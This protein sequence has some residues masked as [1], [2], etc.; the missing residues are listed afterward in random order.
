MPLKT[1]ARNT[2]S[3]AL[4]LVLTLFSPSLALAQEAAPEDTSGSTSTAAPAEDRGASNTGPTSPT[5]ADAPTYTQNDDGTWSNGTYTWDPNTKQT[6]PNQPQDY[7][8]NPETKMWDTTEYVYHPEQGKYVPNTKSTTANPQAVNAAS[9][10]AADDINTTGPNSTNSVNSDTDNNGMFDLFFNGAISSTIKSNATSGDALVQSNTAAGSALTGDAT[11]IA[12]VLNMLQSSWLGQS[13]D[14]ATFIT[15]IDGNVYGDLTIDPGQLPSGNLSANNGYGGDVDIN[16]SAN[17]AIN[18]DI[19]LVA[20]SGDAT[21][22]SNTRGGDATSGNARAM[23]NIIN[24]INSSIAAGQSFLGM[25]NINGNFDGDILLPPGVLDALIASTGPNSTNNINSNG[26]NNVDINSTANRTIANNVDTDATTGNANVSNNTTAGGANSGQASTGVN[27]LNL[28]G[29]KVTG[30]NGLLV[31]VNVLGKWVGMVVTPNGATIANSGPGSNNS[32]HGTNNNSLSVDAE[33]NSLI[34]NNINASA[35]SGDAN[36]T[37]NTTAGNAT[38]GNAGVTVSL[39]NMI[40]TD[41][42]VE[43]WFGVLF[44][45]VFGEWMG[46]FGADTANGGCSTCAP[47]SPSGGGNG[48]APVQSASTSSGSTGTGQVFGFIAR[49][50][51]GTPSDQQVTQDADNQNTAVFG[52]STTP[53]ESTGTGAGSDISTQSASVNWWI[54]AGIIGMMATITILVRE[55]VLALRE[56]K[57]A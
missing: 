23:A 14:L 24:M 51:T 34:N 52:A 16:V 27:T 28:V 53:G 7:S 13:G 20:Q 26:A 30:K 50:F 15:N 31:F 12:N 8:Y 36:V 56:E 1:T 2:V 46:S 21:V 49:N 32:V 43:D 57:L 37:N 44:I 19:D 5:G 18:N 25:I 38:T 33:E 55:Y 45:N 39:I 40:G 42:N 48:A 9:A 11:A 29:Q 47:T 41:I 17:A 4:I 10:A 6:K 3:S 35:H 54:V 22:D